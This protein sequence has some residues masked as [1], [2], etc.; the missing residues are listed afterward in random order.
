MDLALRKAHSTSPERLRTEADVAHR[1]GDLDAALKRYYDSLEALGD[2]MWPSAR[3]LRRNLHC[4]ISETLLKK[5]PHKASASLEEADWCVENDPGW[6][7]GHFRRA[8]ALATLTVLRGKHDQDHSA[9]AE[10]GAAFRR[11]LAIDKNHVE[12]LEGLEELRAVT[13]FV[14]PRERSICVPDDEVFF[15]EFREVTIARD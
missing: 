2:Q 5:G 8:S 14:S 12:A 15:D 11:V 4:D 7:K 3:D 9:R 1:H 10:A 6:S 13:R